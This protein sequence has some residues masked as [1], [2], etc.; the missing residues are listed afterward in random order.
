MGGRGQSEEFA[1]TE[2]QLQKLW[3]AC[4]EITDKVLVGLL[5]FCGMRVGEVCHLKL[6]WIREQEI[7]IPSS[8]PCQCWECSGRGFWQPKSRAGIR[9]IPIPAFLKPILAEYLQQHPEGLQKRRQAA[10]YRIQWL[11]NKAGIP[12]AFPHSL[13]ATCATIL[14]SKGFTAVELCAYFGWTRITMG[15]HYIQIAQARDGAR[16]KIKEIYG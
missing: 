3:S 12:Q 15:E 6:N 2:A 1:L 13:R 8:M 14:A 9:T 11:A 4:Y 7:H 16:R 5:A 10:W